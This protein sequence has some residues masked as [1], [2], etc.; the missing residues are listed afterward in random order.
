MPKEF[1]HDL[2]EAHLDLIENATAQTDRTI[3]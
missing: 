3:R 1:W 2:P